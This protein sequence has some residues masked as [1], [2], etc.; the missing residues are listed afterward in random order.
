MLSKILCLLFLAVTLNASVA[1]AQD[2]IRISIKNEY[3]AT[4]NFGVLGKGSRDGTDRA[5]GVLER[6]GDKYVGIVDA[7]VVSTQQLTGLGGVGSC[8]PGRFED[9]QKLRVIGHS[10]NSFNPQVQSV[11]PATM[12]GQASN[13]YL[14]LE[15]TP[16]TMPTLQPDIRLPQDMHPDLV[17][18][19]HTLIDTLSGIAFLPLNDS[20]WTMEGG[21]YIIV[22]PSSGKINYTDMTVPGSGGAQLGP[23]NA[24]KSV[25]TIEVERLP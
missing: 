6:Q 18:A 9:S 19:C 14:R 16:E 22:L 10:E 1:L 25:W 7:V 13:K 15:F 20:R 12:T 11:D 24:V 5:E 4:L 3:L 23:F 2:R 21:G 17:V 8:G